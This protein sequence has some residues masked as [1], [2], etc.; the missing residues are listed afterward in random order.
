MMAASY[1]EPKSNAKTRTRSTGYILPLF[2]G[3]VKYKS[4]CNK[5]QLDAGGMLI[6]NEFESRGLL[7]KFNEIVQS[8]V[9]A[10]TRCQE[11]LAQHEAV[12]F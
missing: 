2:K 1:Q 4:L 6:K 3:Y 5:R 8:K 12:M 10:I 7:D 9:R 11:A